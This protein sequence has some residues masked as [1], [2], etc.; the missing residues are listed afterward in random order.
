MPTRDHPISAPNAHDTFMR[1]LLANEREMKR[2]VSALVPSVCDAEE[3]VQQT[4]I[5]LWDKFD[6]YDQSR[7]FAPW[8]CRFSLNVTK[9]WMA[10]RKRWTAL[11][12]GGLAEELAMR[13]EALKPQFDA[14]LGQLE[15]CLEKLPPDHRVIVEAYYFDR[16]DIGT[17]AKKAQRSVEAAYKAL[18]RIRRQLRTCIE[19]SMR[20][21]AL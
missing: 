13:R 10:R 15:H 16:L 6:Q 4:A 7:P 5:L 21:E 3:I 20:E 17:V 11:L 14:R 2:Y 8:A 1:L 18:Q 12:A 9:Q 19:R